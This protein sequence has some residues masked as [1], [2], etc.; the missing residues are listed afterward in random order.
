MSK[1]PFKVLDAP[2]L[3][4]DYYLNL[5]DWSSTNVLGVGLAGCVYL[6]S[7]NTSRV[8]KLCDL[9][10]PAGSQSD[11]DLVTSINW[12]AKVSHAAANP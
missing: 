12:T 3:A 5:V 8:T 11:G 1:G 4:D 6:W 10:A 7:A 2:D 9:T